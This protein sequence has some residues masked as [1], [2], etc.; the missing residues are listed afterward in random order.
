[1]K[2]KVNLILKNALR[3][4]GSK[5]VIISNS[6]NESKL[7]FR[8]IEKLAALG[9]LIYNVLH[10]PN[11][12]VLR[13]TNQSEIRAISSIENIIGYRVNFAY[14]NGTFTKEQVVKIE[15]VTYYPFNTIEDKMIRLGII[16]ESER[17]SLKQSQIIELK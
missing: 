13:L 3:N 5:S 10:A 16:Q 2:D 14:L 9:E 1:M 12:W 15:P 11:E 8:E 4:C 6:F 17:L 7:L